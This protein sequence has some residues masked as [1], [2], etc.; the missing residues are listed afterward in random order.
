MVTNSIDTI[1]ISNFK[2]IKNL[3]VEN[4]KRINLFVGT[5]NAG[6]SNLLEAVS[7]LMVLNE[8]SKF[9]FNEL[10]RLKNA[11]E[12]FNYG[13]IKSPVTINIGGNTSLSITYNT[14]TTLNFKYFQTNTSDIQTQ[15]AIQGAAGTTLNQAVFLCTHIFKYQFEKG[16]QFNSKENASDLTAFNGNNLFWVVENNNELKEFFFDIIKE[17]GLKFYNQ[18][19]QNS[20]IVFKELSQFNIFSFSFELLPDTVQRLLFYHTA[21]ATNTGNILLFEEPEAHMFPPYIS[22][23]TNDVVESLSNQFFI[24]THSPYVINDFLD[25]SIDDLAIHELYFEEGET[26]CYTLSK[27]NLDTIYQMGAESIFLNLERFRENAG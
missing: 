27:D 25:R 24:A 8:K 22:K 6:K 10:V 3:K 12:L 1:E 9:N 14:D 15:V 5:P 11:T 18:Q 23:F 7:T 19:P 16:C 13:N 2:S 21:I 20:L 26:K 4:C 17:F